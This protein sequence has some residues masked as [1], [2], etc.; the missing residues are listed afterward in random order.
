M[1]KLIVDFD[2]EGGFWYFVVEQDGETIHFRPGFREKA[3][4]AR[5]GNLWI[6]DNLG[7]SPENE[8]PKN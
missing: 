4:A 2:E 7:A 1:I 8:S 5:V 3:E 6:R